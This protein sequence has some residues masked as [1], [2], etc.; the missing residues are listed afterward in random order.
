MDQLRAL[1]YIPIQW[2]H[3]SRGSLST[4]DNLPELRPV[5]LEESGWFLGPLNTLDES[6]TPSPSFNRLIYFDLPPKLQ[7]FHGYLADDSEERQAVGERRPFR[8]NVN[9]LSNP[10]KTGVD[11]IHCEA[12][13]IFG[14]PLTYFQ[15]PKTLEKNLIALHLVANDVPTNLESFIS[16]TRLWNQSLVKILSSLFITPTQ[17]LI[18]YSPKKSLSEL[19]NYHDENMARGG[20][21]LAEQDPNLRWRIPSDITKMNCII[22]RSG[23]SLDTR[24]DGGNLFITSGPSDKEIARFRSKGVFLGALVALLK[25][26]SDIFQNSWPVLLEKSDSEVIETRAWLEQFMNQWWWKRISGDQFL[27]NAY[28]DWTGALGIQESLEACR[29]DLKE[30]WAIRT[31]QHSLDAADRAALDLI[32]IQKLNK[33]ARIF[34]VFGIIPA[35]LGL[36]LA[37]LPSYIGITIAMGA[38]IALLI[39]PKAIMGLVERLQNRI[40][41]D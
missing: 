13:E 9:L 37:G 36:V 12:I 27:Q 3:P 26:Q 20:K 21:S 35:W 10:I 4:I 25:A 22:F 8:G 11:G 28:L 18:D 17:W 41:S 15:A 24:I 6:K 30:Y 32:E 31:M 14:F 7:N 38:L 40:K 23:E 29:E 39:K 33:L 34:A 2:E 5:V 16:L 19:P 1:I